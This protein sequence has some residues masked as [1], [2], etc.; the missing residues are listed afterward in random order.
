MYEDYLSG[1]FFDTFEIFG[2][3]T[4]KT[5][6]ITFTGNNRNM[7]SLLSSL[8]RVVQR[9]VLLYKGRIFIP[10]NLTKLKSKD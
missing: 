8:I 10:L 1:S 7:P 3:G 5:T 6:V 2:K 4:A 9:R